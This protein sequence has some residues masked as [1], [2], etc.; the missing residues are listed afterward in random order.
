MWGDKAADRQSGVYQ[1]ATR[2]V[3]QSVADVVFIHGLNEDY[4][5]S[6]GFDQ[7]YSWRQVMDNLPVRVWSV[8]Y[9]NPWTRWRTFAG[10][11]T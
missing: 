4:L 9:P 2:G 11:P 6:W 8:D 1:I 3:E 5:Q 10:P 7:P